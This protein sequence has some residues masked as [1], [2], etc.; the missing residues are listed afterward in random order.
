MEK[1][2]NI[3]NASEKIIIKSEQ[4]PLNLVP[5]RKLIEKDFLSHIIYFSQF[6]DGFQTLYSNINLIILI[7]FSWSAGKKGDFAFKLY[8]VFCVACIMFNKIILL[9]SMYV[10]RLMYNIFFDLFILCSSKY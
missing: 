10:Y 9:Q 1:K 4:I 7:N 8:G 5:F 3:K 2:T 6:S